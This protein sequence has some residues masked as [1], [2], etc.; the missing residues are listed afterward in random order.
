MVESIN[1]VELALGI[2]AAVEKLLQKA[3][4]F[5]YCIV[6]LGYSIDDVVRDGDVLPYMGGLHIIHTPGHTPGSMCLFLAKSRVLIAGDT[7]I[8]NEDRLS[9]PLPLRADRDES[10]QSLRKLAQLDFD[11]CCFGHG[12]P[13]YSAKERVSQLAMNYP[14]TPLLWRIV[15][16]WQR[17]VRFGIRLWR[18]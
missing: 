17:L 2:L 7:I 6:L 9:R 4:R 18:R 15:R 3:K 10:E 8:N 16:S 5:F 1:I 13:L 11:I 12:P 14:R